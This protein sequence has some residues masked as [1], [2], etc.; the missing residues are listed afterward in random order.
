MRFLW[1]EGKFLV[2]K[3]LAISKIV[4]LSFT[5]T[6]ALAKINPLNNIQRKLHKKHKK[7][8]N[9]SFNTFR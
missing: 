2:F 6:I 9:K 1:I 3:S 8:K 5:T 7:S 4:H